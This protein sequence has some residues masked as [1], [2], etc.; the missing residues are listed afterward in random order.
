MKTQ[1]AFFLSLFIS[2]LFVSSLNW[3]KTMNIHPNEAKPLCK[4]CRW[5]LKNEH[6]IS[7]D[8]A[9]LEDYGF[10]KVYKYKNDKREIYE[11]AKH[12]REN[13][14]QCGPEGY[15]Y[16]PDITSSVTKELSEISKLIDEYDE[17]DDRF[18]VEIMEK[19]EIKEVEDEMRHLVQEIQKYFTREY[20]I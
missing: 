5:F 12:S 17:L 8:P 6:V 1:L 13:A 9:K 11:Y 4:N 15:L 18:S 3:V 2:P 16:E 14:A 7:N 19:E 20:K 10:C